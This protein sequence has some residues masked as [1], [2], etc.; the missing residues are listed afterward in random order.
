LARLA[1]LRPARELPSNPQRLLPLVAKP[2]SL[3]IRPQELEPIA[4]GVRPAPPARIRIPA[5]HV[6]AVVQPVQ[7]KSEGLEVP[8][9][10]RAG[11]FDAGPRP[12]EVGRAVVIGHLDTEK[13][14]GL[15][16]RVPKIPAGT[17]VSITDQRGGVHRF[18]VIGSTQIEKA[19]FPE[20]QVYGPSKNPV[21]VLITCGGPYTPGEGYRDNVLVYARAA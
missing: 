4:G 20:K 19:Q 3:G 7:A 10:G 11:W 6:N 18:N 1:D 15:F 9:I 8:P 17:L 16:A 12:G 21:L 13:G 5:A 2:G 14:P